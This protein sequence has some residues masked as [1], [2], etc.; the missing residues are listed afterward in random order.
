[1]TATLHTPDTTTATTAEA[2][3]AV[4]PFA[5]A[6]GEIE[7]LLEID[8]DTA[9]ERFAAVLTLASPTEREFLDRAADVMTRS[10]WKV[11]ARQLGWMA[12]SRP[13]LR[14]MIID[15]TA[16]GDPGLHRPE[17][18]AQSDTSIEAAEWVRRS[19]R[20]H[21]HRERLTATPP[22]TPPAPP[23]PA[24]AGAPP[25]ARRPPPPARPRGVDPP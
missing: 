12:K 21:R 15:H 3:D 13:E 5:A 2:A 14:P 4:T 17:L 10:P 24:A 1:M 7:Y 23:Y 20:D 25:P 22:A 9:R 19:I 16:T 8:P 11:A 6:L 18:P